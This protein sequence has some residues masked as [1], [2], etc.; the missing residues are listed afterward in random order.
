[1]TRTKMLCGDTIETQGIKIPCSTNC[2]IYTP[3]YNMGSTSKRDPCDDCIASNAWVRNEDGKWI[4][5]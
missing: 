3:K 2:G 4:K 5:A 1:M